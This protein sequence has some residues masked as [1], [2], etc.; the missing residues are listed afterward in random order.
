[1]KELTCKAKSVLLLLG[2]A[3]YLAFL[4]SNLTTATPGGASITNISTTTYSGT[5]DSRSDRGGTITT[6]SLSTIAQDSA[7]KAYVGNISG[8]L[9]LRNSGGWSIYQW[10]LNA[11]TMSANIFVSRNGSVTWAT[12]RCAN[13]TIVDS[14]QTFFG[15]LSTG[16][17][18]INKTFNYTTHRGMT[19]SSVGTIANNTC[20][21]TAT[22]VNGT[23]QTVT[24]S[25]YFQEIL[26]YDTTNLVYGTFVNQDAWGYDNNV[27]APVTYDFQF[28]V[29]E[30]SS[31]STG[32]TYYFYADITG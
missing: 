4:F 5:P 13:S 19:I 22:N 3:C 25:A 21:S 20:P 30:N 8:S 9:V 15:M 27:S 18:T 10:V 16:P 24:E 17:D 6:I 31:A 32:T 14:E 1:V 11:S 2:L 29:A 26:L 12:I 23:A 7:W 28:I